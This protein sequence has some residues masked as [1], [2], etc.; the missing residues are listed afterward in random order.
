MLLGLAMAFAQAPVQP[1]A[2]APPP[3]L[4]TAVGVIN[5]VDAT[6]GLIVINDVHY[7]LLPAMRVYTYD[8]TIKDPQALRAETRLQDSRALRE[9]MR[10]GYTV[11]GEGAG[12]RGEITEAWI[13]PAGVSLAEFGLG[14]GKKNEEPAATKTT[15][16][17]RGT[18]PGK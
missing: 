9:G 13:L 3:P 14:K 6:A 5:D 7:A 10:I 17:A 4:F 2:Q 12:K 11:T 18:Q 1:P 8:R 15:G 16:K